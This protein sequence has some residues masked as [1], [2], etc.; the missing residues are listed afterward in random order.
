VKRYAISLFIFRRDLRLTDNN[1]L[2]AALEQSE[3]LLPCFIFDPRQ[4]NA[5]PYQSKP[6]LQFMLQALID[7]R[8]QLSEQG[9]LLHLFND[10]PEHVIQRLAERQG[11]EAVFV[12]RDYT[13]FS[14]QRDAV[15]QQ[16][17]QRQNL[18]FHSHADVLLTEPEQVHKYDNTPYKVFTAFYNSARQEPVALP[19]RLNQ[20]AFIK[21]AVEPGDTHLIERFQQSHQNTLT[22]GRTAALA[23]LEQLTD[24]RDYQRQRDYPALS[25]TSGLSAYLKFGCCSIR[26][27]YY[28]VIE[29]L[30][31]EHPLLRQLYWRDFFTHIAFHFPHVFGHA[32]N[33]KYDAISWRNNQAEFLC[34]SEGRTG[35]PIVDAGIR[36]LNQTGCMHN[37]VRMIVASFLVKDLHISW[38][39][40]ERYFAQHLIDYD[41]CVNNGNWQWAASTG[42]DAQPYFRIFNPW[43]QQKKFDSECQYIKRWIPE[44]RPFS[45]AVIH[46]WHKKQAVCDYPEPIIDH[47]LRSQ[48]AKALFQQIP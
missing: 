46:Q 28:A 19:Q 39:W 24:C 17:C 16:C 30:G 9:G 47:A 4:I 7:L 45:A 2:N 6:A 18:D 12:N 22:G 11:I 29:A 26:E 3:Q 37:R 40:G 42:C 33:R 41:P 43:L 44:L 27:A 20:G 10:R 8:Q 48:Q 1:A 32:F 34:W 25:A 36:E 21:G 35:F 5:H 23:R 38:V 13:P 14:Q 15:L 31:S